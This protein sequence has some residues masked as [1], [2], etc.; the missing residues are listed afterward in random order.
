MAWH[1]SR[2]PSIQQRWRGRVQRFARVA[3]RLAHNAGNVS[4]YPFGIRLARTV[5][6]DYDGDGYLLSEDCDDTDATIH[7]FA[8]DTY[9]DGIDSDCDG[10]DCEADS[11]GSTY[12]AACPATGSW[13]QSEAVCQGAGYDGLATIESTAETVFVETLMSANSQ[14]AHWIGYNDAAV[15]GTWEW[16]SGRVSSYDNW[17]SSGVEPSGDGDCAFADGYYSTYSG[18]WN[19]FPCG[20]TSYSSAALGAVCEI[21]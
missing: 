8:G 10:L 1:A 4:N 20:S 7:P 21:R 17:R 16:S 19:D 11:D 12:F 14:A 2:D 18:E 15:E 13:S 9:G 5:D 6:G 3:K